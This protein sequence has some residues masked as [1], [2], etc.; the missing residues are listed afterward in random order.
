MDF[1][2]I[3]ST[4]RM[5]DIFDSNSVDNLLYSDDST[6]QY[7]HQQVSTVYIIHRLIR[8]VFHN[9]SSRGCIL[10]FTNK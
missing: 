4:S 10:L 8:T 5:E 3:H 1:D 6:Q 2:R 9:F 7:H